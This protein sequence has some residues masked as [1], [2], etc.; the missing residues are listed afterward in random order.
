[1][2]NQA[3][4]GLV[5]VHAHLTNTV[6]FGEV[7]VFDSR[8]MLEATVTLQRSVGQKDCIAVV[9]SV[10]AARRQNWVHRHALDTKCRCSWHKGLFS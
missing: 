7:T 8:T 9:A 10:L 4:P 1:M 3:K 2:A 5:V 6:C